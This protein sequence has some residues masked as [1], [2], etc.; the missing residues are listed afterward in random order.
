MDSSIIQQADY[1]DENVN[2]HPNSPIPKEGLKNFNQENQS[3]PKSKTDRIVE[4]S[5][6]NDGL[7]SE[8]S[9]HR[10]NIKER[11]AYAMKQQEKREKERL[12]KIK[13]DPRSSIQPELDNHQNGQSM[14]QSPTQKD[15]SNKFRQGL[16]TPNMLWSDA[17]RKLQEKQVQRHELVRSST[18]DFAKEIDNFQVASKRIHEWEENVLY[19]PTAIELS[20]TWQKIRGYLQL[21]FEEQHAYIQD[22]SETQAML[23]GSVKVMG[24]DDFPHESMEFLQKQLDF[25]TKYLGLRTSIHAINNTNATITVPLKIIAM[26]CRINPREKEL[27]LFVVAHVQPGYTEDDVATIF[28]TALA[29]KVYAPSATANSADSSSSKNTNNRF[30][31]VQKNIH[32]LSSAS[33]LAFQDVLIEDFPIS[34]I[35]EDEFTNPN[36]PISSS[37]SAEIQHMIESNGQEFCS[38]EVRAMTRKLSMGVRAD[39]Q[40]YPATPLPPP[41]ASAILDLDDISPCKAQEN[42]ER[43]LLSSTF[44]SPYHT[45]EGELPSS[46]SPMIEYSTPKKAWIAPAGGVSPLPPPSNSDTDN[47]FIEKFNEH[48][49][50]HSAIDASLATNATVPSQAFI[51]LDLQQVDRVSCTDKIFIAQQRGASS[52]A[53]CST[54]MINH[55]LK[56][57]TFAETQS[58]AV[59]NRVFELSRGI[60]LSG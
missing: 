43:G 29:L 33:Q 2:S 57:N 50:A 40:E 17:V 36:A 34:D 55:A 49:H 23:V 14:Y 15:F 21:S 26:I 4:I 32:M 35:Y 28:N 47:N 31:L 9:P 13:H 12:N 27:A 60:A 7:E 51:S 30:L 16:A 53:S 54:I 1:V 39:Y 38:P 44:S 20:V 56:S 19:D 48:E 3:I 5:T 46:V 8:I 41:V 6:L 25:R 45:V 11:Y 37:M 10:I 58:L 22:V 24:C 59:D 52:A 18:Q 42:E